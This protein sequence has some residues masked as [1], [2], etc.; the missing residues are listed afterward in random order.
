VNGAAGDHIELV[1]PYVIEDE[2]VEFIVSTLRDSIL[3]V[4]GDAGPA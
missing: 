2:H 1:P 3:S 4:C